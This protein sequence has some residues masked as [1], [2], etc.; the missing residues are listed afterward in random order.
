M[1]DNPASTAPAVAHS[2]SAPPS[3]N[4][5]AMQIPIQVAAPPLSANPVDRAK[6]HWLGQLYVRHAKRYPVVRAMVNSGWLMFFPRYRWIRRRLELLLGILPTMPLAAQSAFVRTHGLKTT[7]LAEP[8]EVETPAPRAYPMGDPHCLKSPHG[9]Y[10]FPETFVAELP[11]ALVQG[12]THIVVAMGYAVHHDLFS[13][14]ED[15]T[16]EEVHD[17]MYVDVGDGTV[18]WHAPDPAPERMDVAANFVDA[19]APNYAHWL[20]EVAPRIALLC[21]RPEFDGVPLIVNDGLHPNIMESLRTLATDRHPVVALPLGRS[22]KVARLHL[23]SSAGYVPFEPR[24]GHAAGMSH[25]KF[26][27]PAFEAM[28]QACFARLQPH[29]T[30]RRIFLRRNS[31]VRR[32]VNSDAIEALLVSRGFT[33][34]EP[35]KLSFAMQVQLFRQAAVIIGPTGAALANIIFADS[36]ARIAILISRQEGV[37]YWYWQ[38]IAKAS[39]KAVSYVFGGHAEGAASHVHADFQ[40]PPEAVNEFVNDLENHAP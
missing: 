4:A 22:V 20:T 36:R 21:A 28:R 2:S 1:A 8:H 12:G 15:L 39:G 6:N 26:S 19:C 25:G 35:E 16:S 33:V 31:G 38:N 34:V 37:I 3:A 27:R 17:R 18:S 14:A 5:A 23:V 29:P 10:T 11:D 30:P 24:G 32:L 9:R 40:V 7:V 13:R